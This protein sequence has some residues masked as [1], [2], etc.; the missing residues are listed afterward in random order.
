MPLPSD[1]PYGDSGVLSYNMR[2]YGVPWLNVTDIVGLPGR[3][4][5]VYIESFAAG[6]RSS[7]GF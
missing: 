7:G 6:P 1:F 3:V 5:R 4:E 2:M